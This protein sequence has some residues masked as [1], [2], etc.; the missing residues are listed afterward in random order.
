MGLARIMELGPASEGTTLDQ[1]LTRQGQHLGTVDYMSPEQAV[2]ARNCDHRTDIYSLGCTLFRLLTDKPVYLGN[3]L[4]EK[5][6]AHAE[7]AIPN[8]RESLPHVPDQLNEVFVKMVAKRP[9]ER[10]QSMTEVL[11]D[12]RRCLEYLRTVPEAGIAPPAIAFSHEPGG[13]LQRHASAT[14]RAVTEITTAFSKDSQTVRPTSSATDREVMASKP[15]E[16]S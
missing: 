4:I 15:P 10:Y 16:R 13:K 1:R 8:L 14:H 7:A 11:A 9:E 12:L 6:I 2:D 5:M 3:T